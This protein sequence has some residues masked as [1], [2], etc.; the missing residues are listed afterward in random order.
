MDALLTRLFDSIP[1]TVIVLSTLLPNKRH[2]TNINNINKQYIELVA[3]RRADGYRVVLADMNTFI[4]L[5]HLVDGIHPT[6]A[7]YEQ[8]AAVWWG[9]ISDAQVEKMLQ[10]PTGASFASMTNETESSTANP[11]L[12]KLTAAPQPV[13]NNGVHGYQVC[14]PISAL[15]GLSVFLGA[16]L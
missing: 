10:K 2:E 8:M 12:L 1:E 9:A 3:K 16:M 4:P 7:G 11:N 5:D 14:I 15:L 13:L 6:D